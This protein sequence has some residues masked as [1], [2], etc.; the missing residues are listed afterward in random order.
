MSCPVL[1]VFLESR[2]EGW[3]SEFE[4]WFVFSLYNTKKENGEWVG[5]INTFY[6]D[7]TSQYVQHYI[8]IATKI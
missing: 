2:K 4:K 7:K 3:V 1:D 8:W 6:L 5:T